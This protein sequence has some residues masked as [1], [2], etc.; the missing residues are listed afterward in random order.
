M[1]DDSSDTQSDSLTGLS[2]QGGLLT[3]PGAQRH[4]FASGGGGGSRLGLDKLAAQKVRL[5]LPTHGRV[6]TRAGADP[7][8]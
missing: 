2:E 3:R 4:S 7:P 8:Q 1:G 6:V 5:H